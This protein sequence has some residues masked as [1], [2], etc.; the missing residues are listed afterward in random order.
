MDAT[1]CQKCKL[2]I[3]N[4]SFKHK[5]QFYFFNIAFGLL[6]DYQQR[7]GRLGRSQNNEIRKSTDQTIQHSCTCGFVQT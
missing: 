2:N 7:K 3:L 4:N 1:Q 6:S 5:S